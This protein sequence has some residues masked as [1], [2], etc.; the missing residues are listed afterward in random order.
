MFDPFDGVL[1]PQTRRRLLDSWPGVFRHVLLEL[2][3]ADALARHFAPAM[4]RPSK[5]LYSMAGLIF[6]AEY[7]NWTRDEALNAYCFRMDVHYALNLEP[8][9]QDLSIRT[10]ERN[11]ARF[12]EDV[13]VHGYFE[14]IEQRTQCQNALFQC[15]K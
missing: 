11:I 1:S 8:V 12:K 10:L 13:T 4:G 2:M 3:P 6:L 9:A 15:D 5:E 7:F 14:D